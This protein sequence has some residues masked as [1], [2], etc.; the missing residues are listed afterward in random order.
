M[1]WFRDLSITTKLMLLVVLTGSMTLALSCAAFV[2]NDVQMIRASMVN[3]VS[4]LAQ[5]LGSNST[6]AISFHDAATANEL[7]SALRLQP[8]VESACVYDAAGEPFASYR[9][10]THSPALPGRPLVPG[11]YFTASYLDVIQPIVHDSEE[12]GRIHVRAGMELLYSQLTGYGLI[13]V[14]VMCASLIAALLVT[15]RLQRAISIPI[16]HLAETAQRVS[17]EGDYSLRVTKSTNDELGT[18][19]DAF[20]GMLH[21]VQQGK[22]AL[23]SAQDELEA[24]VVERTRQL[25]EANAELSREVAERVK[26]EKQLASAHQQLLDTARRAGMAEIAS[27]VLHNVG[28]VLNGV[29]VSATLVADRLRRF[30]L[31]HVTRTAEL[32]TSH[33]DDLAEYLTQDPQGQQVPAFLDRTARHLAEEQTFMVHELE[34]LTGKV[35]HIK[36][37]VQTQQNYAGVFGVIETVDIATIIDD[38]IK[39]NA[40]SIDRHKVSISRDYETGILVSLDKQKLVQILVNIIKNAKDAVR[41]KGVGERQV[42]VRVGIVDDNKLRIEIVDTGEGIP[43]ENLTRIFSH[44]FTT[45]QDGHGFGLH[46][47]ANATK[48]MGGSLQAFSDGPGLGAR[49]VVELPYQQAKVLVVDMPAVTTNS[50]GTLA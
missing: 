3:E 23:Q 2:T 15:S 39:L 48:E 25:S 38:A 14:A 20:N 16:L 21:Q 35:E 42:S 22:A 6:A 26:A 4:T 43:R 46:S 8:A 40:A 10:F 41:E 49:F 1:R 44:G 28:N 19:F 9:K 47:S 36:A 12:I 45:K 34:Q 30:R 7:L 5:V 50:A 11:V 13:V 17:E 18:L 27:N 24:R 31:D 29:N 33:R 37:I 32:I